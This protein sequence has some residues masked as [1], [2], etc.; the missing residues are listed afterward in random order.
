MAIKGEALHPRLTGAVL[1]NVSQE[2]VE[3]RVEG[4]VIANVEPG[5]PAMQAGLRK[6]D[7]IA[8]ANR[9]AV[10]DLESLQA[11]VAG[12]ES[13]LLNLQRGGGALFLLLR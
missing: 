11:A 3:G 5:S 2:T 7:L 9:Q 10:T 8:Q 1:A 6:G 12:S 13:L 4:V